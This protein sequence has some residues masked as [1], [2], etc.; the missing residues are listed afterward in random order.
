MDGTGALMNL[1]V[2]V[3]VCV[4]VRVCMRACVFVCAFVCIVCMCVHV[5]LP[6]E[7]SLEGF[8]HQHVYETVKPL[9]FR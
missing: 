5:C 7:W 6:H 9:H 3:Y 8:N 1:C 4:C 2:C